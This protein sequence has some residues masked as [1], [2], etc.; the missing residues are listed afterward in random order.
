M[1]I[2]FDDLPEADQG[3]LR[4]RL[5]AVPRT[6]RGVLRTVLGAGSAVALGTFTLI[7]NGAQRAAAATYFN[8]WTST[9]SGPCGA[10]GYAS[11]HTEAGAT[12]GPSTP[13]YDRTCCWKYHNGAGNRVGWH[14]QGPGRGSRYY[15]HRPDACY[16]GTYDSWHWRFS[17][18]RTYRCSDGWTCSTTGG[19]YRSICPWAV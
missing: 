3:L 17:D 5:V 11:G 15:T 12:C 8:D 9:S 18:G 6:R 7:N 1:T 14:T 2:R 13:C 19:C 10:G 4:S 16:A